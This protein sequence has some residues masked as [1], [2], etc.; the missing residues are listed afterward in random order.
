MNEK[1]DG[2]NRNTLLE[3][4]KIYNQNVFSIYNSIDYIRESLD[5]QNREKF[6]EVFNGLSSNCYSMIKNTS[7]MDLYL[8][9]KNNE[10]NSINKNIVC[11]QKELREITETS[12]KILG[13]NII[14]FKNKCDLLIFLD[15][16][17]ELLSSLIL[18]LLNNSLKAV[19]NQGHIHIIVEKEKENCVIS[20]RD[21]G[22]GMSEE[23]LQNVKNEFY[24]CNIE[25][26]TKTAVGVGLYIVKEIVKYLQGDVKINSQLNKGTEIILEIPINAEYD[27]T[28]VQL[29]SNLVTDMFYNNMSDLYAFLK[30]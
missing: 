6:D 12:N 8:K 28:D 26:N 13:K 22:I 30:G 11:I 16:E 9:I 5:E 7:N 23:M 14:E 27:N 1:L 20:V 17:S 25:A 10:I 29:E 15:I 18:N 21:N 4:L 24:S 2:Y 3:F 19:K